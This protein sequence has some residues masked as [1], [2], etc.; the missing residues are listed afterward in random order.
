MILKKLNFY[1]I[2]MK[3]EFH[4]YKKILMKN[5][6]INIFSKLYSEISNIQLEYNS[7]TSEEITLKFKL[8][9]IEDDLNYIK[10]VSISNINKQIYELKNKKEDEFE[11]NKNSYEI[12]DLKN[13]LNNLSI[14]IEKL[15]FLKIQNEKR[16]K[17]IIS[18]KEQ[19]KIKYNKYF[20]IF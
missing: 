3:K 5:F 18:K 13:K 16:L 2:Q 20:P 14:N 8:Y 11:N 17:I 4:F 7:L 1:L 19:F 9:S 6:L 12:N 10:N 15:E